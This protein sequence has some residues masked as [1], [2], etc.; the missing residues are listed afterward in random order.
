MALG[1]L[2]CLPWPFGLMV[3][4][5]QTSVGEPKGNILSRAMISGYESH[6][7]EAPLGDQVF[8]KAVLCLVTPL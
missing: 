3:A 8:N 2:F 4:T 5:E 6:V 7:V 1:G